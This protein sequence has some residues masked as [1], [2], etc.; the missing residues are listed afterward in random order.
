MA[1]TNPNLLE[2]Y[3]AQLQSSNQGYTPL[4]E[5]QIESKAK[6]RYQTLYDQNRLSAQQTYDAEKLARDQAL[7]TQLDQKAKI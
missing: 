4:T 5:A 3:I 6:N 7:Q 2:E 1:T